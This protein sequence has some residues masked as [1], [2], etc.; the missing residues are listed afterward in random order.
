MSGALSGFEGVTRGDESRRARMSRRV[1]DGS[2]GE[3]FRVQ[4][5]VVYVFFV[6]AT[7]YSDP[8]GSYLLPGTITLYFE[9]IGLNS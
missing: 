1:F 9:E 3:P 8:E 4:L 2:L 7:C 6:S 5:P